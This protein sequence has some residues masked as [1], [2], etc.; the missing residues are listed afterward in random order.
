CADLHEKYETASKMLAVQ[1]ARSA[2]GGA[3][4]QARADAESAN[5]LSGTR[6]T[7]DLLRSNGCKAPTAAPAKERYIMQAMNCNL[8]MIDGQIAAVRGQAPDGPPEAC[9]IELW[10]PER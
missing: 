5:I 6:I 1:F 7:M 8:A 3:L 2:S 9:R 10:K 4:A